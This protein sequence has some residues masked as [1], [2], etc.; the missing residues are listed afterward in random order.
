MTAI[1]IYVAVGPG[2]WTFMPSHCICSMCRLEA[3]VRRTL[4]R[5]H[6]NYDQDFP[7]ISRSRSDNMKLVGQVP[8]DVSQSQCGMIESPFN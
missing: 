4:H 3:L 7:V 1:R 8:N 2:G 5:R 6:K